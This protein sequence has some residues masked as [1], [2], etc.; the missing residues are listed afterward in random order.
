MTSRYL[1]DLAV[2]SVRDPGQAAHEIR[3]LELPSQA[4]WT[5]LLLAAVLKTA[6]YILFTSA[7]SAAIPE[8]AAL[9]EML[10]TAPVF[11][12][13]AEFLVLLAFSWTLYMAGTFLGGSASL[14]QVLTVTVWITL[15]WVLAIAVSIAVM[16]VFPLLALIFLFAALLIR[17]WVM[18]HFVDT[19]HGLG[20]LS[21]SF[22]L[23]MASAVL[24]QVLVSFLLTFLFAPFMGAS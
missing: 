22:L 9:A 21:R 20:S 3:G 13:I 1:R 11:A 12:L 16:L 15:L 7:I 18:V 17:I 8:A 6:T 19:V 10:K 4:I 5:A 2:L 23:L 24:T 14:H